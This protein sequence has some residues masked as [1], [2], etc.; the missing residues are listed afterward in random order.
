MTGVCQICDL[1]KTDNSQ[2]ISI[3]SSCLRNVSKKDVQSI[4][5][6][7]HI[8]AREPFPIPPVIPRSEAGKKCRIC[9]ASC[10][11]VEGDLGWCGIHGIE[12]GKF[13]HKYPK[14]HA[15]LSWYLDPHVTNCCNAW[16]CPAGTGCGYPNHA[17]KRGPEYDYYNMSLFFYGCSFNCLFCQ[18]WQH[19][20]LNEATLTSVDEI[21]DK[22]LSNNR[23][24][25]WCWFGGSPEPQM[26]FTF[27][28]QKQLLQ[29][30]ADDRIVRFCYEW[31]GDGNPNNALRAGKY[32][33]ESGG[34]IKFDV[35]AWDPVVHY[36]LTGMDNTRV[37]D[38]IRNIYDKHATH[39][40]PE[41]PVLGF[42]TLLVPYYVGPEEIEGIA[43][44]L[45][46]IDP[47]LPYSLLIFHP[48]FQMFDLPITPTDQVR[49]CERIAQ[50]Y[51]NRVNV[52]NK[53][54]M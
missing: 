8:K 20:L 13:I 33:C 51:L 14:D 34:N 43:K 6:S 9:V 21:V 35:K 22:T 10:E 17:Y 41:N 27:K 2:A 23:I 50:T 40:S 16:W 49:E 39:R 28:S 1:H 54:L 32:A 4:L 44:F 26:S 46:E 45:A 11:I 5:T 3:C 25:C 48:D 38:N 36:A 29:E 18:N 37:L 15:L 7:N 42:S 53:H 12:N 19:K 47:D 30:K 31:N 24:S 52:G